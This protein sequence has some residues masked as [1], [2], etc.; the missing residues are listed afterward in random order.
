MGRARM[1]VSRIV[2]EQL[3]KLDWTTHIVG[4][5]WLDEEGGRLFID[6]EG[7]EVPDDIPPGSLLTPSVTL[8]PETYTWDWGNATV[9]PDPGFA[10]DPRY[11]GAA[12]Q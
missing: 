3:L 8:V 11:L 2:V 7:G 9:S 10:G 6:V 4:V 1:E 12:E 5:S